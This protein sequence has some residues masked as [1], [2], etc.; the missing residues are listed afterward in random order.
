VSENDTHYALGDCF[1]YAPQQRRLHAYDE[2]AEKAIRW[3]KNCLGSA[4]GVARKNR[5][6]LM[7]VDI[8]E[9]IDGILELDRHSWAWL[10]TSQ[11]IRQKGSGIRADYNQGKKRIFPYPANEYEGTG[12]FRTVLWIPKM[13]LKK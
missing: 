9:F 10:F 2:D 8:Y 12:A 3:R 7:P 6:L 1:D 4:G 13:I 11:E 5:V